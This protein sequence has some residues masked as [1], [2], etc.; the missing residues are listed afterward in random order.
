MKIFIPLFLLGFFKDYGAIK[1]ARW[2]AA[3]RKRQG[4][5]AV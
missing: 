2:Q 4:F 5:S 3:K 1:T